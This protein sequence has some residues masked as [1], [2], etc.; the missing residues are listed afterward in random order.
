M[1]WAAFWTLKPTWSCWTDEGRMLIRQAFE[2]DAAGIAQ[3]H[4]DSWR[5]TYAGLIPEQALA[6]RSY[7]NRQEYWE[8]ALNSQRTPRAIFVAEGEA[9]KI[10]GFASGGP[11][12]AWELGFEAE[13]YAIYLLAAYQGRGLGSRLMGAVAGYLADYGLKSLM[14]WVLAS[15]PAVQFYLRL[16]GVKVGEKR[17]TFAGAALLEHAY[18]WER[19]ESLIQAADSLT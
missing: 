8:W 12:R 16:G 2:A 19:I 13:V 10:A 11:E 1:S 3:V 4:V 9:G 6:R 14:V 15:N 7:A 5:T 18:G 17:E